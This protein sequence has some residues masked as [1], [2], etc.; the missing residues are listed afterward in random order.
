[1]WAARPKK[2]AAEAVRRRTAH[3][4]VAAVRTVCTCFSSSRKIYFGRVS[5][6]TVADYAE[7]QTDIP[8]S[9]RKYASFCILQS[10]RAFSIF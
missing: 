2:G 8:R 3:A 1:M 7:T 5:G 4:A 9:P 6:R 10:D